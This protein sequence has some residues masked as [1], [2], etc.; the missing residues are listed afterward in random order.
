MVSPKILQ[1]IP[2]TV[3]DEIGAI[4]DIL[5][6]ESLLPKDILTQ[7]SISHFSVLKVDESVVSP[8]CQTEPL[9]STHVDVHHDNKMLCDQN[10]DD[11][12]TSTEY[13]DKERTKSFNILVREPK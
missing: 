10:N 9:T 6:K 11:R 3:V 7:E 13:R 8:T 12:V 1:M 2:E 4:P 5:S